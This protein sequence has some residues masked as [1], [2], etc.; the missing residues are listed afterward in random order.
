MISTEAP[1]LGSRA[2]LRQ[3][4]SEVSFVHWKVDPKLV[5]RF[6]PAGCR[7]DV[8]DGHT[9]VGLIAFQMSKS[10]FF[11]GP[12]IPWLGDFPEVNVRLYSVDEFGRKGVVFLSLEASHLLPVLAARAAFALPYQWAS[13]T[14]A[15]RDG[16]V[17]YTTKR[18]GQ[19]AAA[20]HLIVRPIDDPAASVALAADDL[21]TFVTSRWGFH[22]TRRGRTIYCRNHHERWPLQPAELVLLDD[23]LLAAAGLPGIADRVPDSVLYA[24]AVSTVFAAPQGPIR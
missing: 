24:S 1:P 13:M 8:I 17:A 6:M 7:P 4:W 23:G 14:L 19:P 2:I 16:T 15:A 3:R 22:E 11:G 10:S 18:H 9:M 5:E 21:A 12:A 20:S